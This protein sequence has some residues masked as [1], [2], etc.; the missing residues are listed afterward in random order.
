MSYPYISDYINHLLGTQLSLP[1]ATF[2]SFV[3]LAII[4]A[5]YLSKYEVQWFESRGFLPVK[6]HELVTDLA[7]LSAFLGIIGARFFHILEHPAEFIANPLDMVFSRAGLSIYGGLIFGVV[8]GVIYLKLK[9]IPLIPS[10]DAIAPSV[11]LGYG[12]GRIGCQTSG[13]GDWGIMANMSLKPE[14]LPDWFW[15]QTYENNIAGVV[16]SAPGVYPTP[17]YETITAFF[18]FLVLLI[19]RRFFYT[20]GIIISIYLILSGFGRLLIEKIRI[21]PEYNFFGFSFTQAEF[22]SSILICLGLI[23]ILKAVKFNIFPKILFSLIVVSAL[24]ACTQI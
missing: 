19:F 21:N 24:S 15:A 23:G 8:S 6:T 10:L 17:I 20:Q 12:I 1:I 3:A 18:I 22:I 9:S 16:I 11:A 5:T 2:G 13:D 7:V 4:V 14:W